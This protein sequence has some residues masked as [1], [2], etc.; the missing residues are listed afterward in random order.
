[1]TYLLDANVLAYFWNAG[2]ESALSKTAGR[3]ALATPEH[4]AAELER[5]PK[6][7]GR[8]RKWLPTSGIR[9]VPIAAFSPAHQHLLALQPDP[10]KLSDK[11]ERACIALAAQ[12][13]S[14]VFVANDKEA[15]WLALRELH[16]EGTRVIGVRV[17]LRRCREQGE[18]SVE[19]IDQVARAAQGL[20]PTW[21]ATWRSSLEGT[22]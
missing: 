2:Q 7:G 9:V 22:K 21:W 4:V 1:M 20:D 13:P 16:D 18:L 17:F 6:Y 10:T 8:F 11:G 12:D 3:V 14:F 15:L 5:S 19:A